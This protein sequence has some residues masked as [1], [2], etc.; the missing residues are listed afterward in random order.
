MSRDQCDGHFHDG[1]RCPYRARHKHT[2][3][4]VAVDDLPVTL[5]LCGVHFKVLLKRERLGS[6]PA[7]LDTWL[8]T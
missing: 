4:P 1:Q 8:R 6:E 3:R 7:L 2:I 5:K